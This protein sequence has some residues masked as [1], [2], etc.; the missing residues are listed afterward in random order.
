MKG[1]LRETVKTTSDVQV[2]SPQDETQSIFEAFVFVIHMKG[3]T[4]E[5][6]TVACQ[7]GN[8]K[9]NPGCQG[10]RHLL[11]CVVHGFKSVIENGRQIKRRVNL[12]LLTLECF[13]L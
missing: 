3:E 7:S 8:I 4:F 10:S 2:C 9:G 13:A 11:C 1:N 6:L 5:Y 12:F